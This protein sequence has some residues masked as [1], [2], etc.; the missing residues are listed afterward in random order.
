MAMSG[1]GRSAREKADPLD[2]GRRVGQGVDL[3]GRELISRIL[4]PIQVAAQLGMGKTKLGHPIP[5]IWPHV[6]LPPDHSPPL[7][8]APDAPN[9]P[10]TD[11]PVVMV[12]V[13]VAPVV[14]AEPP[15]TGPLMRPAPSLLVPVPQL[16][17]PAS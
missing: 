8:W 4:V 17:A 14:A 3:D 15:L 10:R 2:L 6:Q 16:L 7:A 13:A 12:A 1:D 9:P 5:P 11:S